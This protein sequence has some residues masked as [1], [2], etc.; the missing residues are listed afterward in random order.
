MRGKHADLGVF[1]LLFLA[2]AVTRGLAAAATHDVGIDGGVYLDVARHVRDGEGLV[3]SLSP[4]NA[5]Y[6]AFP[7]P[8]PI[9][10]LWPLLLGLTARFVP[11]E[12]AAHWLP[13]G[14]Y[15]LA[16]GAWFLAGRRL[17][18]APL[19]GTW[20]GLHGGHVAALAVWLNPVL[21][22]WSVRPYTE[23]LG[24]LLVGVVLWRFA[25]R[26]GQMGAGAALD[27]GV[28]AALPYFARAQLIL[29]P[30][31]LVAG[32]ALWAALG[33]DRVARARWSLLALLPSV[34]LLGGWYAHLASFVHG[35]SPVALL[36][37][38]AARATDMLPPLAVMVDTHGFSGLVRDRLA[39]VPIAWGT[40]DKS[41]WEV[42]A[43]LQYALPLAGTVAIAAFVRAPR[44]VFGSV[45]AAL[46]G[47]DGG[48]L[49][50]SLAL[51]GGGLLSV[52]LVHKQFSSPWYFD[53]RE[54]LAA[55]PAFLLP[56]LWLLRGS[57]PARAL[58]V[59]VFG[60]AFAN[61]RDTFLRGVTLDPPAARAASY[62][63][64]ADWLSARADGA[65]PPL[66]VAVEEG[67][68]QRT[69]WQT[70]NVGVHW[71]STRSTYD[72][73]TR[74]FTDLGARLLVYDRPRDSWAF[75]REGGRLQAEFARVGAVPGGYTALER[76]AAPLPPAPPR[77][78]LVIGAEG[79]AA[80]LRGF[81]QIDLEPT[82]VPASDRWRVALTGRAEGGTRVSDWVAASGLVV[83]TRGWRDGGGEPAAAGEAPFAAAPE[84]R[85]VL[86]RVG[87]LAAARALAEAAPPDTTVLVVVPPDA[88]ARGVLLV[89]GPDAVST[90][91][92]RPGRLADL[93]P[94]V[95]WLLGLPVADDLGGDV[96][97]D[98]LAW[99]AAGALGRTEVP[100]WSA[101][102]AATGAP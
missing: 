24:W 4:Y 93:A 26:S 31:A 55:L 50:V 83:D 47:P 18:G 63:R 76:R 37:F 22:I 97:A 62:D 14:F 46:R 13:F 58:G 41:W 10:P 92:D 86:R 40:G 59:T 100:T 44:A 71:V 52:H 32:L 78:L 21:A 88:S 90:R 57:W 28:W 6:E 38:D 74:M 51:A 96:R 5:G 16:G 29:V 1:A 102:E 69:A 11:L 79:R 81:S 23:P 56:G 20:S 39:G 53:Q 19:V 84:A 60:L 80:G 27:V 91:L 101:P 43:G 9:Y 68:A 75:L 99:D 65:D 67:L 82:A 35:A 3:A 25:V 7:H 36:R 8:S 17:W 87:D 12:A 15:L 2:V 48:R 49:A 61:A 73:V 66:V 42:F 77:R 85:L 64:L 89:D 54:G 33:P 45:L 94:T 95:A 34:A 72:T 30:M 70:E 98:V